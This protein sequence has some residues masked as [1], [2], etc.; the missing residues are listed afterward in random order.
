MANIVRNF[1]QGRM[2]KSLDERLVPNGEYID[3]LN[4]RLGSTEA[5]EVGSVE[6]TKGNTRLTT[7]KFIDVSATYNGTSLSASARC[8]GS[9]ADGANET[10]YWFIHDSNYTASGESGTIDN[11]TNKLDLIVSYNT[12]NETLVYHVISINDGS[13]T[14][15]TLNFDDKHLITGVDLVD[16]LLFF[17]DDFNA[18]RRINVDKDYTNPDLVGGVYIDQFSD[19]SILVIKKPPVDSPSILP[20]QAP[21][22]AEENFMEERFICFAYRYKYEDN[23]YSATSQFSAPSFIPNGYNLSIES[24][25]NEGMINSTNACTVTFNSG[26]PLVVGIDL[27]FKEMNSSTIKVIEKI[28]KA[29]LGYEDNDPDATFNFSNSK[30]FTLLPSSEILRLYD[31][32][33]R[34]A[35]AQTVM[36]NRLVYGNYIDGYNLLSQNGYPIKLEYE[37]ERISREGGVFDLVSASDTSAGVYTIDP[38]NSQQT[39]PNGV[40]NVD[41]SSVVF[42]SEFVSG[43][44][45]DFGITLNHAQW[46]FDTSGT[47]NVGTKPQTSGVNVNFSYTLQQNF[48]SLDALFNSADFQEKIGTNANILPVY[49]ASPAETSCDGVTFTDRFNCAVP[50]TIP[51]GNPDPS[52]KFSSGIN[53]LEQ[54]IVTSIN[55]NVISFQFPAMRF[56]N[57][58][59]APSNSLN[60]FEYYNISI[61][62]LQF[63]SVLNPTSLHSNRDYEVGIV[64]MD[65][66][67]RATTA[68]VSEN[69]T[70]HVPCANSVDQNYIKATIPVQQL[71]PSFATRYKFVIKPD[72]ENYE[73]VYSSIF[74]D[75]ALTNNTYFL[76]EG[77]NSQKVETGD[78]LIVKRDVSSALSSCEY[79]T[80][81]EKKAQAAD[82]ITVTG[83]DT[84]PSGVY[85][86]VGSASVNVSNTTNAFFT[87]TPSLQTTTANA[88]NDAPLQ[89]YEGL[90]SSMAIPA[91]TILNLNQTFE[92]RGRGD[93]Q[94]N[95]CNRR[96][97]TLN[98]VWV[99]SEDYT[100]IV[101]W[102]TGDNISATLNDGVQEVGG[103]T[104]EELTFDYEGVTTTTANNYGLGQIT[105][106]QNVYDLKCTWYRPTGGSVIK[107]ITRGTEACGSSDK[108]ESQIRTRWQIFTAEDT[109]VFETLPSDALPDVWYESSVSYPITGGF[110]AGGGIAQDQ[111]NTNPALIDLKFFNCISFGNGVESYK[112][113]DSII[114]KAINLG[115]RVT[116]VSAQ[117]YKEADRFA[118]LTYSGVFNNESNV[119]KL[120]E[121]NLGLLNFK[122]LEESFGPVEKLFARETDILTL[123]E[124][125][126]S[127]VM[128]GKNLLSDSTGGGVVASVPEVLGTQISRIEKFGISNNPESFAEWGPHKY[129]TDAK[130]GAVIHL[131]GSAAQ[132][133]TLEVISE[134][135][136]RS[137]FRDLFISSFNTQKIGGFDPYMNEYVLSSN[138]QA[139]PL[140]VKCAECGITERITVPTTGLKLCYNL[141]ELVGD[142]DVSY[143]VFQISSGDTFDITATYNSTVTTPVSN[144]SANGSFTIN[145][146]SV[147]A[148][149]LDLD[150]V[151]NGST[152][153]VLGITV[154]CP[155]EVPLTLIQVGVTSL[156][157]ATK[158]IH[159]QYRW[160]DGG[161]FTSALHSTQMEFSSTANFPLVSQYT[162][163]T[164]SQGANIIPSDTAS[165]KLISN[166]IQPDDYDFV[167]ATD[168]FKYLRSNTLYNNNETDISALL[169]LASTAAPI[170]STLAPNQY[171]SS[172][173]MVNSNDSYLYLIWDY[174]KVTPA[175]LCFGPKPQDACCDC[176]CGSGTCTEYLITNSGSSS[177]V[178]SYAVCSGGATAYQTITARSAGSVCSRTLPVITTGTVATVS[179]SVTKCECT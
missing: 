53:S 61:N 39:V 85:M 47:V 162:V 5:T 107:W 140:T 171:S 150:F 101:E 93:G 26:G 133:E 86:K 127:Y 163:I 9:Y 20:F 10:I 94:A 73:T 59:N 135:G 1:V 99:A 174:R 8:I 98:K 132:N 40:L 88:S 167:P 125:K 67:N 168:S 72:R 52:L 77:E 144:A 4:I 117:D 49:A 126:I 15:T 128:A 7:L 90:S 122:P 145:K 46:S 108:K 14:K 28:N 89:V 36:G 134:A 175:A 123:Q 29:D 121:F 51:G 166:K 130:R 63:R 136:M 18:P 177:V 17:T 50:A 6:N 78:R 55:G 45:I 13:G 41:F 57:N 119:N 27:L 30:I 48:A 112:I 154:K 92:R 3:A 96:V 164:G 158:F 76:L 142:V 21:G 71:P 179:I 157:D 42:Q 54:A 170:D 118:D 173:N 33:P 160:T 11:P 75:E 22:I 131:T 106:I 38:A 82:F 124:D 24:Y 19:E 103:D 146:N 115:N 64:Y 32:V 25:L 104:T 44:V 79:I 74:F 43:A 165:V 62:D 66:Y 35:K 149:Q 81:L 152:P 178:I 87:G 156:N 2:N 114:G 97:Y 56:V 23:E 153:I 95:G 91:G 34:F 84:V 16:N 143:T 113:R 169:S 100:D 58:Q 105:N 68:L 172:F 60:L 139:L 159:N 148:T 116:S 70:I 69:N 83:V 155:T 120:N 12:V 102:F 65:D 110:H 151:N 147:A 138:T 80:V 137:W 176:V 37:V 161:G 31:N 111:S 129:F 109:I 141:G